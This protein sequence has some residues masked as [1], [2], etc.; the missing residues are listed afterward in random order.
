MI[1][2]WNLNNP[3]SEID[4]TNSPATQ[5]AG[6][7]QMDL[8]PTVYIWPFFLPHPQPVSSTLKRAT[9]CLGRR[10]ICAVTKL[11]SSNGVCAF[12]R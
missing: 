7:T 9:K 3:V 6:L 12:T 4:V 8:L 5:G 10:R 2:D 11:L 1:F